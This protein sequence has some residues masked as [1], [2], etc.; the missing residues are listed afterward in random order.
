MKIQHKIYE[1]FFIDLLPQSIKND[2]TIKNI[3]SSLDN[4]L[5]QSILSVPNILIY[6]RLLHT[7]GYTQKML[8]ALERMTNKKGGIK[9]L[10]IEELELLA[11]QFH[12][13]FS[14]IARNNEELAKMIVHS[15]KWH[16]I[17][18]TPASITQAL[19][20][21]ELYA[22][23]EENTSSHWAIYQ[24]LL[25]TQTST[26]VILAYTVA[27]VMQPA[28]CILGRIYNSDNDETYIIHDIQS[29]WGTY[30]WDTE[31]GT[32][33][34]MPDGDNVLV[35]LG[36]SVKVKLENLEGTVP[37]A[38]N[39]TYVKRAFLHSHWIWNFSKWGDK[40]AG[41]ARIFPT[42]EI[43]KENF[44]KFEKIN[45]NFAIYKGINY[46]KK[47]DIDT[48]VLLSSAFL[49]SN[50]AFL[51]SYWLWNFSKWG[52]KYS[53]QAQIFSTKEIK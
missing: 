15:I 20:M 18:G 27:K 11:W 22:K 4:V 19:E 47:I 26:D 25:E 38:K 43:I 9:T 32:L 35:S 10:S 23:L 13:D 36:K 49:H 3:V 46:P 44:I 6:N 21:F 41:E 1:N 16:R 30:Y 42:K 48:Y 34:T 28:R 14:E 5:I 8:P 45:T 51:H 17:K 2:L 39:Y 31:S 33:V 7:A 12:V 53:G 40:Y 37:Y 52:D 50:Y 29:T 24:M